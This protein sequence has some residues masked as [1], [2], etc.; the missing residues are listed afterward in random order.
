MALG[1]KV[2]PRDVV[3][4][5]QSPATAHSPFPSQK[6]E[7]NWW[8]AGSFNFLDSC[9]ATHSRTKPSFHQPLLLAQASPYTS[10]VA[11]VVKNPPANTGDMRD[12]GSTPGSGDPLEEDTTTPTSILAWRIPRTEEPK[13]LQARL[14]RVGRG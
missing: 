8:G 12:M 9:H 14:Q 11:L 2:S 4:R 7:V 6:L 5:P 10:Q 1:D 13:G 3:S